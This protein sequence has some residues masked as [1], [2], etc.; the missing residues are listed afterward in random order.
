MAKWFVYSNTTYY[1]DAVVIEADTAEEAARSHYAYD[2]VEG[3]AVFPLD[4]LA[5]WQG[6][7]PMAE[8]LTDEWERLGVPRDEQ[9]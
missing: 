7:R 9:A 4:A 8:A 2:P 6:E 1:P 5:L 3:M